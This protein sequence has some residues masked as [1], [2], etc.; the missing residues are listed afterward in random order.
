[1][2]GGAAHNRP[3]GGERKNARPATALETPMRLPQTKIQQL[4][5]LEGRVDTW[6]E[7]QATI[8]V[9]IELS[10]STKAATTAARTAYDTYQQKRQD[11]KDARVEW[12]SAIGA[13]VDDGRGCIRSI[14][15]FAKNSANPDAVYALASIAPPKDR[16]PLGV[17]ETP[18]DLRVESNSEGQA[19]LR[20]EGTRK[21]GTVFTVQ[22][23]TAST[24]GQLTPWTT[25]AT[26]PER[27]FIDQATPS[28]VASVHYRV[29]GERVG[30]QS[31]FSNPIVLPLGASGNQE[32]VAGA[33]APAEASGKEAG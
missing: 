24:S 11:A 26:V 6:E 16:A 14:D 3:A 29:R 15:T 25:L 27:V 20:W 10:A 31:F 7:N 23:R 30:G 5:Y 32:Q 1:M 22:R 21:G 8:G 18:T 12:L 9:S 4:Q 13:A 17:P 19:I 28:G 33:I 2:V